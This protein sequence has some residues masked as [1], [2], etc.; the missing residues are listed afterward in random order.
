MKMRNERRFRGVLL[1]VSAAVLSPGLSSVAMAD[2]AADAEALIRQGV[3]LRQQGRDERALPLF[4]KAY[5]IMPSPR[6]AGQLGLAESA[7]GYWI[8]SEQHLATALES[9][10]HPW[11]AKNR[12]ALDDAL[13]YVRQQLGD[14]VIGGEPPGA[15]IV[16]NRRVIGALPLAKAIRVVKGKMVVEASAPGFETA[17]EA[18]RVD[19]GDSHQITFALKKLALGA[20]G[21]V[22]TVTTGPA[23]PPPH[24][25]GEEPGRGRLRR[26]AGWASAAAG[27]AFLVAAVIETIVWQSKRSD[28][29]NHLGPPADNPQLPQSSWQS[30]CGESDPGR[31]GPGCSSLYDSMHRAEVLSIAGYAAAGALASGAAV[32]FLTS[33]HQDASD[34]RI[35]CAASAAPSMFVCRLSF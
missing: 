26:R 27:G 21:P 20:P 29:E 17:S 7:T 1:V 25:P 33:R 4:Q 35:A 23:P 30:N 9:S 28:F 13:V 24:D 12:R 8:E 14:L 16:V 15:T 32:L 18:V 5:T 6:T 11:I 31:G 19:G 34:T 10:D 2:D 3:E 22:G